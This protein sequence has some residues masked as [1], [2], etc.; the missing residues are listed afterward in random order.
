[1]SIKALNI[2]KLTLITA[3]GLALSAC[4]ATSND[5]PSSASSVKT[6]HGSSQTTAG[7]PTTVKKLPRFCDR[8]KAWNKNR[9]THP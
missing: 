8:R 4:A 7:E 9:C 2:K 5:G 3:L 1:M 6:S